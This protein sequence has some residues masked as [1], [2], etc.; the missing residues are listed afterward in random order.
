[1]TKFL[2]ALSLVLFAAC[3]DEEAVPQAPD[4]TATDALAVDIT[5]TTATGSFIASDSVVG[6][7]V[8]I[9]ETAV[10]NMW[11]D[12]PGMHLTLLVDTEV[13][14]ME[15]DGYTAETGAPTQMTD[16]DRATLLE[17][18]TALDVYGNDHEHVSLLRR[19][20]GNWAETSD[21]MNLQWQ[22]LFDR[23]RSYTSLCGSCGSWR[24]A[25]HDCN[26]GAKNSDATTVNALVKY[27]GALCGGD[28]SQYGT[29]SSTSCI[30]EP[31]GFATIEY[32]RGNCLGR[33][34]PGCNSGDTQFT[35]D[36]LNHD[37]CV[38]GGHSLASAYCDD[39][40]A[41]CA[42]DDAS[43]PHCGTGC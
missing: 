38:R 33:C 26:H 41:A 20:I 30:A 25:T 29:T 19:K 36:C 10:Y 17:L 8:K 13:G 37:S 12:V 16:A 39:Q 35:Q 11:V 18:Y 31:Q 5:D 22:K 15:W 3:M 32:I 43:A 2:A 34:G 23:D 14:V 9:V 1:M 4:P 42:D 7:G 40:L 27:Q 24:S 21:T 28:G 6:F